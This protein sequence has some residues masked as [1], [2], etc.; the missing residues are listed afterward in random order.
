MHA[1]LPTI[2]G[3]G[4]AIRTRQLGPR[5]L[6]ETVLQ[7]I[8]QLE[9]VLNAHVEVVADSARAQ[10]D[11]LERLLAGGT[12]LGP[13]HG[14]PVSIKD[15]LPT[16]GIRTTYGWPGRR[17]NVP[18]HDAA[19]VAR[20][21]RAGAVI[22]GKTQTYQ[23]AYGNYHPEFG[24]VRNPWDTSRSC[25]GSSSGSAASV[26]SGMSLGSVGTDAAGSVRVPGALAGIVAYKP[27]LGR[28]SLAGAWQDTLCHA[29]PLARTVLDATLLLEAMS[30]YD[31]AD[32]VSL[33]EPLGDVRGELARGLRGLVVGMARPQDD[34]PIDPEVA[35][36][37]AEAVA[38]LQE[39]GA[40]VV[41]VDLPSYT[42]SQRIIQAIVNA[43]V[44]DML[45]EPLLEAPEAFSPDVRLLLEAGKMTLGATYVR[46]QRV[47]QKIRRAYDEVMRQVDLIALPTLPVPAFP[48]DADSVPVGDGEMHPFVAMT[49]HCPAANLTGQPALSLPAGFT[50][51]GLPVSLQLMGRVREDLTVMRAGHAYQQVTDWHLREPQ[52]IAA[53]A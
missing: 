33:H 9:P 10:A 30:G 14:I 32:P 4:E 23:F 21:R 46:A 43:E 40:Q 34:D 19:L 41:E 45:R 20:L 5:E 27:T 2:A 39:A 16:A 24:E 15:T 44:Q 26:A 36:L 49:R 48:I 38:T 35:R 1:E 42:Q 52:A 22:V 6:T 7:R 31:P 13:L 37:I 8:E 12:W 17:D 29:G 28:I 50:E 51:A 3:A 47:R 53:A 11:A 25:G 18:G